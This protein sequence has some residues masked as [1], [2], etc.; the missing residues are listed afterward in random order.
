V[1]FLG[2][3]KFQSWNPRSKSWVKYEFGRFGFK[4]VDVKQRQPSV[5][6]KGVPVRGKRRRR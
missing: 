3:K 6:F 2:C 4:P 5:K 1:I